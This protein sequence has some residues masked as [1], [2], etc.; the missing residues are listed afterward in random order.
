MITN[1][2]MYDRVKLIRSCGTSA[3]RLANCKKK[4]DLTV[5]DKKNR[6]CKITDFPVSG[7]IRS[8][9]K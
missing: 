2:D 4:A 8:N 7:D 9:E 3:F 1:Q 6:I 5:V